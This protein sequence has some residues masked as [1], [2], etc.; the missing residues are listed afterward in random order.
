MQPWNSTR[1]HLQLFFVS[2]LFGTRRDEAT[3]GV[4]IGCKSTDPFLNHRR[5]SRPGGITIKGL[6]YLAHNKV[7]ITTLKLEDSL[8]EWDNLRSL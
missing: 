1:V 8:V 4:A 3:I 5:I 6:T 2:F 7:W